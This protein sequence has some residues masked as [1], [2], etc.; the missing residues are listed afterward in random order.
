MVRFGGD[1][2]VIESGD[3]TE[4]MKCRDA[5][6]IFLS[7]CIAF[8]SPAVSQPIYTREDMFLIKVQGRGQTRR[9]RSN[10]ENRNSVGK[11]TVL[12]TYLNLLK[13]YCIEYAN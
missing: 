7:L 6:L 12:K 9:K 1:G 5:V 10:N 4:N 3:I 13:N 8:V 11:V 2:A